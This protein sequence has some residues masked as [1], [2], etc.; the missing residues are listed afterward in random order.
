MP[1]AETQPRWSLLAPQKAENP[2]HRLAQVSTVAYG[3]HSG[4][5]ALNEPRLGRRIREDPRERVQLRQW[6][7]H[8]APSACSE[9]VAAAGQ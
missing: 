5:P 3:C 1:T 8:L 4:T 9:F 2:G 6:P 7:V